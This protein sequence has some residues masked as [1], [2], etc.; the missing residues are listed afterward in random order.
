MAD[1]AFIYFLIVI[2]YIFLERDTLGIE[3]HKMVEREVGA[4]A[5]CMKHTLVPLSALHRMQEK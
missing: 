1:E 3:R 4:V 5:S 2:K